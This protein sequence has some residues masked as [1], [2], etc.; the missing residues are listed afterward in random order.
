MGSLERKEEVASRAHVMMVRV[1]PEHFLLAFTSSLA[2]VT[3]TSLE[4]VLGHAHQTPCTLHGAT[5]AHIPP[6]HFSH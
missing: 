1:P 6:E 2:I 3:W 4:T 5:M